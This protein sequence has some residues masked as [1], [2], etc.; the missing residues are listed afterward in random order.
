M[1]LRYKYFD[2]RIQ[3][4]L[5]DIY[6]LNK[7]EFFVAKFYIKTVHQAPQNTMMLRE[8]GVDRI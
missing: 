3:I 8:N 7:C 1:N 2:F 6:V 5:T 4:S